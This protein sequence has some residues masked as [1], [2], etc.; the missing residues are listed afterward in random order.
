MIPVAKYNSR[1]DKV[2]SLVCVG[3]DPELAKIPDRFKNVAFP[4]FQFNK[5]IIDQTH[6]YTAAYKPNIAFYEQHGEKGMKELKMTIDYINGNHP[7]IFTICDAKRADIGNTNRAYVDEFFDYFR[8][9]SVTLHPYLGQEAIEPFL[10]RDDKCI[11][12]LVRTS[13]KGAPEFQDL[14]VGGKKVWEVVAENVVNKWNSRGNCMLF[15]GA[16]YPEE[17]RRARE[18][19]GEMTF[20]TAG[21]GAQGGSASEVIKAGKNSAG[22]GLIINS[23]RGIIFSE[24]PKEEAKKLRDEINK[25]R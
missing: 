25:W 9:D 8:F 6:E 13:N 4:Q 16:T 20:L 15:I 5:W 1:A 23:S 18:I 21:T 7:D 17:M 12:I 22:K 2:N 19:A 11:I 10:E 3:L 24:D 14:N